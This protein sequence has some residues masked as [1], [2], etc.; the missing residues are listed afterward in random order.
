[1]I[2][3]STSLVKKLLLVF[4]IIAGLYVA[5]SFLIPLCIAVIIATFFV[6]FCQW[7]ETKGIPKA[8]AVLVCLLL[9]LITI[10]GIGALLT[11]QVSQLTNDFF[12]ATFVN[13]KK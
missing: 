6:P 5:Q 7:M 9:L 12:L 11:W 3:P 8:I 2:I 13:Y 10:A 4:L 1:M